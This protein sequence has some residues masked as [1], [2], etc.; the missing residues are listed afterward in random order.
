MKTC[1]ENINKD[2]NFLSPA[3]GE[4]GFRPCPFGSELKKF[5]LDPVV[6][7]VFK[8]C[9]KNYKCW[10]DPVAANFLKCT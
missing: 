10:S 2:D 1:R 6:V 5:A 9:Q 4:Q 8:K 3:P 7:I